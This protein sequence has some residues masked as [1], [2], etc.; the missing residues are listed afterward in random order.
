MHPNHYETMEMVH[1]RIEDM[2]HRAADHHISKGK[3][4]KPHSVIGFLVG[5]VHLGMALF[6][7]RS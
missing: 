2:R 4:R 7:T 5:L 1:V 3:T 6:L